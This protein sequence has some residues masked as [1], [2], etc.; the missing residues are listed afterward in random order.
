MGL[1]EEKRAARRA[2]ILEAGRTLMLEQGYERCSVEKIAA[3]CGIAR[4]TFYLY[5]DDKQALLR[6]LLEAL[7]GPLVEALRHQAQV[8][9]GAQSR[10]ELRERFVVMSVELAGVLE[11]ARPF[12]PLHFSCSRAAGF[13][14]QESARW[15]HQIEAQTVGILE[16]AQ[17]RG[18][19]RRHSS[20]ASALAI[21]GASERMLWAWMQ[22]DPRLERTGAVLELAGLFYAGIQPEQDAPEQD[23]PDQNS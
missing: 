8:L 23:S 11:R 5:F 18:L 13:P 20:V 15:T 7:Y 9:A 6:A 19:V 4:G 17:E 10:P 3:A 2:A 22:D 12:L 16:M 1:R 14:G 21:V